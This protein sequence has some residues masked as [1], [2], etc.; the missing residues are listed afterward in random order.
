ADYASRAKSA[1]WLTF[2]LALLL[3]LADEIWNL[4]GNAW[5]TVRVTASVLFT[6]ALIAF[7]GLWIARYRRRRT[8]T[9]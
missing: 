6:A 1:V 7:V 3:N 2:S 9:D 5:L 8:R 4:T